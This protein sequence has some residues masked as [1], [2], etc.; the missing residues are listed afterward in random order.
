MLHLGGGTKNS[1]FFLGGPIRARTLRSDK[2]RMLER[3]HRRTCTVSPPFLF[4]PS[5]SFTGPVCTG[6]SCFWFSLALSSCAAHRYNLKKVSRMKLPLTEYRALSQPASRHADL[7]QSPSCLGS[8]TERER[9]SQ[10]ENT[11]QSSIYTPADIIARK[12]PM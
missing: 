5:T 8:T 12:V 3:T 9:C 7:N 2:D 4:F 6:R 11:R 10:N 1:D